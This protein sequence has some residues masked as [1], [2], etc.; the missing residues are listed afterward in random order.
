[1]H[2]PAPLVVR[3]DVDG[4]GFDLAGESLWILRARPV[5]L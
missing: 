2:P 3:D 1:V 5:K 4:V